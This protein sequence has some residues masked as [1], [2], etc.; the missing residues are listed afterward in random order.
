MAQ[1]IPCRCQGMVEQH[2][3]T[4][5]NAQEHSATQ[6]N[7][8]RHTATHCNALR[9]TATQCYT[10]QHIV[11]TTYHAKEQARC[12]LQRVATCCNTRY[13][14]SLSFIYTYIYGMYIYS[15]LCI[16]IHIYTNTYFAKKQARCNTWYSDILQLIFPQALAR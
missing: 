7:K 3:A 10:L 5:G 12:V 15:D 16:V 11:S 6:C 2:T 1:L 13:A 9:H 14:G 8:L 4:Q